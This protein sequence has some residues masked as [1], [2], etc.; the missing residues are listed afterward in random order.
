MA[1]YPWAKG[2]DSVG[3]DWQNKFS[4]VASWAERI[5]QRPAVQKAYEIGDKTKSNQPLDDEARKNLFGDK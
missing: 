4:N 3:I 2:V 1:I 5:A